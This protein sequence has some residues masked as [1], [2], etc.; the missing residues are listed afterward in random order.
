MLMV[1]AYLCAATL[2]PQE[3][4][5]QNAIDVVP[6]G[7]SRS[8]L[9]CVQDAQATLAQLALRAGEGAYWVVRC[10]REGRADV[11]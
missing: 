10:S 6:L 2:Q 8:E 9:T 4:S 1:V 5:R 7:E 11:G 3:C